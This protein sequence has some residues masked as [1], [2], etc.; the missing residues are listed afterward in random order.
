L[1]G[2]EKRSVD[3]WVRG[4]VILYAVVEAIVIAIFIWKAR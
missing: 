3:P 4:I 1:N 2:E